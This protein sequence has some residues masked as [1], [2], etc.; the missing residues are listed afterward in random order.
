MKFLEEKIFKILMYLSLGIVFAAV[1][2]IIIT[3]FAKGVSALS[4]DMIFH[5]G[6]QGGIL[7]AIAGSIYIVGMSTCIGLIISIPTVFYLNI[8][9]KKDSKLGYFVRLSYDVMF[10][11]PSIVYGILGYA[12]MVSLGMRSSLLGGIIVITL[13][14]L[15]I[16]VRSMDE[17]AK[18]FPRDILD[19]AYSLGATR[20]ET[21]R[22][23]LRQIVPGIATA[24]LLS[25]GRAIGDAAAVMYTAGW[26]EMIPSSF[27]QKAATLPVAV[28]EFYQQPFSDVQDKAYASAIIL[29]IIVLL[30]S[31][32]GRFIMNKFSKNKLQ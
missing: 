25:I 2:S 10:G 12:V 5:T 16:F 30:L 27:K 21:I 20:L 22:V 24:T 6:R 32:G 26:S 31:I 14:I 29:T 17:V 23:V 28:L 3:I 1:I 7:N 11:V 19:T 18:D 9:R 4:W 15:P 13:L 8:F